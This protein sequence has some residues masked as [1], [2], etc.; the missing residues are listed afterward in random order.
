M[1][2]KKFSVTNLTD[3]YIKIMGIRTITI[4]AQCVDHV[5]ELPDNSAKKTVAKLRGQYPF[6]QFSEISEKQQPAPVQSVSAQTTTDTKEA[7]QASK[8]EKSSKNG[9]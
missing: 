2:T 9:K 6:L 8:S 3:S 4:P 5:L 7:E 1:Q